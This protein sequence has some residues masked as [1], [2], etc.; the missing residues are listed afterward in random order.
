M[1]K[2]KLDKAADK[3]DSISKGMGK[4]GK[5]LTL[6]LTIPILAFI[7]FGPVGLGISILLVLLITAGSK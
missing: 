5:K 2:S 7:F 3:M 6:F 4:L 1:S